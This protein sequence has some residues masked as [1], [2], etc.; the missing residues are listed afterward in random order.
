MLRSVISIILLSS[1]FASGAAGAAPTGEDASWFDPVRLGVAL[2]AGDAGFDCTPGGALELEERPLGDEFPVVRVWLGFEASVGGWNPHGSN[3]SVMGDIGFTPI[4]RIQGSGR[5]GPFAEIGAGMHLLSR[6]HISDSK[7]FST[8]FQFGDR[9]AAG[10][11]F[12]D[13][14]DSE[15]AVR[16]QHYSNAGIKEPNP[17]INFYM[18]QYSARF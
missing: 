9:I 14:L 6:T 5:S 4:F 2:G 8:A 13:P 18:L 16:F 12:G 1:A 3:S 7:A 17:G 11:R 10:Y 15:L